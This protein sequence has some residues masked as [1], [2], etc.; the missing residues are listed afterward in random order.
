MEEIQIN[1]NFIMKLISFVFSLISIPFASIPLIFKKIFGN[2]FLSLIIGGLIY[3]FSDISFISATLYVL[4][5]FVLIS[6]IEDYKLIYESFINQYDSVY[7]SFKFSKISER[8]KK[9]N[10]KSK[11]SPVIS[12]Q[13][14]K[15]RVIEYGTY[16]FDPRDSKKLTGFIVLEE[17]GK[18]IADKS[19]ANEIVNLYLLW[20][21]IYFEPILGKDLKKN[22]KPLLKFWINFQDKFKENIETRKKEEYKAIENIKEKEFVDILKELDNEVIEQYPFVKQKLKLALDIFDKIYDIFL[23]PSA[24]LYKEI[25]EKVEEIAKI[26][27][28]ENKVWTRRLRTWEK[29]YNYK[30][31]KISKL[32]SP[33]FKWIGRGFLGDL[34]NYAVLKQQLYPIGGG[35][36]VGIT[37]EGGKAVRKKTSKLI[38]KYLTYH[39][40]GID[41]IKKNIEMNNGLKEIRDKYKQILFSDKTSKIR[42]F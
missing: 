21:E 40:F 13:G 3:Y 2:I 34:I 23:R 28:E 42:N 26:S 38:N 9:D 30:K 41:A 14:K 18:L 15:Y 22:K 5:G 32:P 17:K 24:E 12:R 7:G 11:A 8:Y 10:E 39:K 4:V 16:S 37:I 33:N 19:V 1:D 29:L 36:I 6:F 27:Q 25:Y 35:T 20:R 31:D